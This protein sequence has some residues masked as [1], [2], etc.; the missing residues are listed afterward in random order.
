MVDGNDFLGTRCSSNQHGRESDRAGPLNHDSIVQAHG[1]AAVIAAQ[2]GWQGAAEC[3]QCFRLGV[4][5][6]TVEGHA[7]G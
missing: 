1:A 5:G 7:V 6:Q 2:H 4:I 3:G